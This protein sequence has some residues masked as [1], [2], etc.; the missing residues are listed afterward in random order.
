MRFRIQIFDGL[1][2]LETKIIFTFLSQELKKVNT[3]AFLL[4]SNMF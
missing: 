2:K 3:I 1:N 4:N